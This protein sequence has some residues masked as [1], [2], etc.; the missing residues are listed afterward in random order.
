MA[1]VG[2]FGLFTSK[3][4]IAVSTDG[5][6]TFTAM[7][8]QLKTDAR[9]GAFPS[10]TT[11]YVS[12][13]N[14]PG[15]GDD[16][17]APK[18]DDNNTFEELITRKSRRI[19]VRK[20]S[21]GDVRAVYERVPA[22]R[23]ANET[24]EAEISKSTDGGKTWTQQFYSTEFYFNGGDCASETEC[25]FAGEADAGTAPGARIYCTKD[26]GSTWTK[27]YFQA[28][29][30]YSLLDLRY[31]GTGYWAV[32]GIESAFSMDSTFLFSAD[33]ASWAPVTGPKGMYV[34]SVD[35]AGPT[36]C[37]ATAVEISQQSNVLALSA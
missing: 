24:F 13:G 3:N 18:D 4:G 9:Y 21:K 14:W 5:G 32:G 15:E 12:A 1:A 8:A 27:N 30:Q 22:Y 35:C 16:D 17:A 10:A 19:S 26:G 29:A 28:G 33:G 37:W 6:H 36:S 31:D 34:T 20:N 25:C 7:D 2:D 23:A 11:F